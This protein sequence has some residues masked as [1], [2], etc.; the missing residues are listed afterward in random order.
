VLAVHVAGSEHGWMAE[1]LGGYPQTRV[2]DSEFVYVADSPREGI[3]R[4]AKVADETRSILSNYTA[5][6]LEGTVA[7]DGR[8][9]PIRWVIHH[10]IYHYSLHIGHMQLTYQLWNKGMAASSPRWFDRIPKM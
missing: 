4:L 1:T 9:V 2:R 10:V 8:E 5:D 6:Q 7:K 3:D